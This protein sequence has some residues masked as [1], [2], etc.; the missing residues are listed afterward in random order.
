MTILLYR[1]ENSVNNTKKISWNCPANDTTA[2]ASCT[3]ND[4]IALSNDK[5][6]ESLLRIVTIGLNRA[7]RFGLLKAIQV[8]SATKQMVAD[9]TNYVLR[10]ALK[11][12]HTTFLC[13]A[14]L[15][16]SMPVNITGKPLHYPLPALK[17]ANCLPVF[18]RHRSSKSNEYL[19]ILLLKFSIFI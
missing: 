14:T 1:T 7:S 6:I 8:I 11:G 16:V 17:K 18:L 5:T 13:Y 15:H 3:N 19:T 2:N 4:P 12:N 10:V 9:G